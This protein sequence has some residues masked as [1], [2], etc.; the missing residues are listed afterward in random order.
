MRSADPTSE[1][2][3]LNELITH[4][5]CQ[6]ECLTHEHSMKVVN[7]VINAQYVSTIPGGTHKGDFRKLP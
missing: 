4:I 3:F 7:A 6:G 1:G 2:C 5:K